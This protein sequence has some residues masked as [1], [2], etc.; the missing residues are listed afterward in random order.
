MV[1]WT[2]HSLPVSL[3]S[4][5]RQRAVTA[6][7]VW[8]L[9]FRILTLLYRRSACFAAAS[10]HGRLSGVFLHPCCTVARYGHDPVQTRRVLDHC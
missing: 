9:R 10:R 1:Y 8:R 6:P 5:L 7:S 3:T 4:T 2:V